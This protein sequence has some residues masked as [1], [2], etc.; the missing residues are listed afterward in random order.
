MTE[1]INQLGLI[2]FVLVI[3]ILIALRLRLAPVVGL[4][5][6]GAII[7]PNMLGLVSQS[8]YIHVFAEIGSILLLFFVG[9]EFSIRKIA[10]TGL[11]S[12]FV[13]LIKDGFIFLL[14]FTVS[15]FFGLD[16]MTALILASALAIS[17]T[18]FFIK[19]VKDRKL[20][21]KPEANL[22]FTV[23]IL[24]DLL[25]IFLLAVYSSITSGEGQIGNINII[26]FS[27]LKALS[28]LIIAYIILERIVLAV[29][30]RLVK[31]KNDEIILFL[32]LSLAIFLS[33]FA[34]SIGLTTGVGAFLAG[35]MLSSVKEFKRT[36]NTLSKFGMLFSSFFFLSIGMLINIEAM[37]DNIVII[38]VLFVLLIFG[39]FSSVSLSA[40]L[41]GCKSSS[42]VLAGL[43]ILS[44]GEFSLLIA[45]QTRELVAPF[46][47][48]SVISALVFLTALSGNI[49]IQY[50]KTIE[51]VLM[52]ILPTTIRKPMKHISIYFHIVLREFEPGG[53]VYNVFIGEAKKSVLNLILVAVI[54]VS[55]MLSYGLLTNGSS[56]YGTYILIA[57]VLLGALPLVS[58]IY[59]I[60]KVMENAS[61]IL[62][63]GMHTKGGDAEIAIRDASIIIIMI[64]SAF[65]TIFVVAFLKLPRIFEF[66]FIIPLFFAVLFLWNFLITLKRITFKKTKDLYK[67]DKR[68]GS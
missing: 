64:I 23:L 57:T 22:I 54:A 48:I 38:L 16:R 33:F 63:K 1:V 25:A 36:Q 2:F 68:M 3:F 18:T 17:S 32:S 62:H 53:K 41:S 27:I 9:I 65:T 14:V 4:L 49:L 6:A 43:L 47:I 19:L 37:F 39:L 20:V 52:R 8:E 59:S 45:A 44:I 30:E 46:D 31:L 61:Y 7:G 12:V 60:K 21:N 29:F 13:W 10:K 15:S 66:F 5:I 67:E 24:E 26:S 28:V 40:Y 11:R 58:I 35:N 51:G 50:N 42:A 55:G 34:S 56:E